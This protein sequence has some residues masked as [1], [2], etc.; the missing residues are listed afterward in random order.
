VDRGNHTFPIS[1]DFSGYSLSTTLMQ[2]IR[3]TFENKNWAV[4]LD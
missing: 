1:A 3:V 2:H 4:F